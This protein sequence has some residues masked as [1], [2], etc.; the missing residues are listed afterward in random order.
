M[1]W[2]GK[3]MRWCCRLSCPVCPADCRPLISSH[4]ATATATAETHSA[5][6]DTD[7]DTA[8]ADTDTETPVRAEP[9][10]GIG[11][12]LVLISA[13][14]GR[15]LWS[16]KQKKNLKFHAELINCWRWSSPPFPAPPPAWWRQRLRG[17][18]RSFARSCRRHRRRPSSWRCQ[19]CATFFDGCPKTTQRREH[20]EA[21]CLAD[22]LWNFIEKRALY[23]D[24]SSRSC[25]HRAVMNRTTT[26][27]AAHE[28][29]HL[30]SLHSPLSLSSCSPPMRQL[31][32]GAISRHWLVASC[33]NL[34]TRHTLY[35]YSIPAGFMQSVNECSRRMSS[36]GPSTTQFEAGAAAVT[37]MCIQDN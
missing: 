1:T 22:P 18:T 34:I 32:Y 9:Q 25:P 29:I 19:P 20:T 12:R 24:R 21:L 15:L 36:L 33:R 31:G 6:T 30:H 13:L 27:G 11:K 8:P 23:S 14:A 17:R 16:Q 37:D 26:T 35:T 3:L 4:T 28:C 2:F 7:T 5:A 10:A